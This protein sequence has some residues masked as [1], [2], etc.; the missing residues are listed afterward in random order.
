MVRP[1]GDTVL[2]V[3]PEPSL[4][5]HHAPPPPRRVC[6]HPKLV[7]ACEKTRRKMPLM[8]SLSN[9]ERLALR[10]AQRERAHY[11]LS[12]PGLMQLGTSVPSQKLA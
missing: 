1:V 10:Q 6:T 3:V 8:V 7:P 4:A 12:A 9:H 2:E 11:D 5:S